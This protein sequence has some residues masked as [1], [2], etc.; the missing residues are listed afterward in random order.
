MKFH[1]Y[2]RISG[3]FF[4]EVEARDERAALEAI[5]REGGGVV[6]DR[7]DPTVPYH[8]RIDPKDWLLEPVGE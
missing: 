2:N 8:R 4:G 5:A 6:C 7:D 1:V 3:G